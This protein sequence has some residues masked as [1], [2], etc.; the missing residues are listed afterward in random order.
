MLPDWAVN[1]TTEAASHLINAY[2]ATTNDKRLLRLRSLYEANQ[3]NTFIKGAWDVFLSQALDQLEA[4][5]INEVEG[6]PP[7]EHPSLTVQCGTGVSILS[8]TFPYVGLPAK[9]RKA[10]AKQ[11]NEHP[12][13]PPLDKDRFLQMDILGDVQY[14]N[15]AYEALLW[16][17][18]QCTRPATLLQGTLD[19]LECY[20]H[21]KA[22]S[23]SAGHYQLME[24]RMWFLGA[25]ANKQHCLVDL[26]ADLPGS[27]QSIK[28][29][30]S[31]E[32]Y[33]VLCGTTAA[34]GKVSRAMDQNR[35][36]A[37]AGLHRRQLTDLLGEEDV[38]F[39]ERAY[40]V[41]HGYTDRVPFDGQNLSGGAK[42]KLTYCAEAKSFIALGRFARSSTSP[43]ALGKPALWL[44]CFNAAHLPA[45]V[46]VALEQ[47][48][49]NMDYASRA[50][51]LLSKAL[52][53]CSAELCLL[54]HLIWSMLTWRLPALNK[55]EVFQYFFR[56]GCYGKLQPLNERAIRKYIDINGNDYDKRTAEEN[57]PASGGKGKKT[58]GGGKAS[59]SRGKGRAVTAGEPDT[60]VVMS[61]PG[62]EGGERAEGPIE[63]EG[64]VEIQALKKQS[65]LRKKIP[66][67]LEC[68]LPALLQPVYNFF[69]I[70]RASQIRIDDVAVYPAAGPV[71]HK[72]PVQLTPSYFDENI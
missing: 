25:I 65:R 56:R 41:L 30:K 12:C 4:L 10:L 42:N 50:T 44:I 11:G 16:S 32:D 43:D 36:D 15:H 34:P 33:F 31:I 5:H 26:R 20:C 45:L 54:C 8:S 6:E 35:K 67:P 2:I 21:S 61:S 66:K 17:F 40:E 70:H 62:I 58:V 14:L 59:G 1:V 60:D 29:K 38:S 55:L 28:E 69:I 27:Q 22:L 68:L 53:E 3:D 19:L 18:F 23:P 72:R 39:V 7:Q 48:K 47:E 46:S 13:L 51:M 52:K 57:I 71:A 9:E 49:A 24:P 37:I 63:V 64:D